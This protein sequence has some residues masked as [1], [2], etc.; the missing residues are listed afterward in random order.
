MALGWWNAHVDV[1]DARVGLGWRVADGEAYTHYDVV[2]TVTYPQQTRAVVQKKAM[3]ETVNL[4]PSPNLSCGPNG[5]AAIV[6]Y[7]VSPK[8]GASGSRVEIK[9]AKVSGLVA[10]ATNRI[11]A[12]DAGQVG[13]DI[14]VNVVIPG[15]C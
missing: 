11:W 7:R 4:K 12:V 5:I 6:T 14:T 15:S 1:G 13:Q 8:A 9:I 2:I 3:N 10:A